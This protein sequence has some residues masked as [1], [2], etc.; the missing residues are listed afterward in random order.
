M[1]VFLQMIW[2]TLFFVFHLCLP[3]LFMQ[4]SLFHAW[5]ISALLLFL[6]DFLHVIC[7]IVALLNQSQYPCIHSCV[8]RY[9]TRR[10]VHWHNSF[11]PLLYLF[12][13]R[14]YRIYAGLHLGRRLSFRAPANHLDCIPTTS[15]THNSFAF[16]V[17]LAPLIF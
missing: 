11:A 3:R 16:F 8:D 10:P 5:P 17:H 4:L 2:R 13:Q 1:F 15:S 7:I 12:P 14:V 6:L 9:T